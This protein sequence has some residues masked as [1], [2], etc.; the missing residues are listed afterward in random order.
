[1]PSISYF[2]PPNAWPHNVS[3]ALPIPSLEFSKK[4]EQKTL[5][6]TYTCKTEHRD[7]LCSFGLPWD[8]RRRFGFQCYQEKR[9]RVLGCL[10]GQRRFEW[11]WTWGSLSC[12]RWPQ[13]QQAWRAAWIQSSW[14]HEGGEKTEFQRRKALSLARRCLTPSMEKAVPFHQPEGREAVGIRH[15]IETS[16]WRSVRFALSFFVFGFCFGCC[17]WGMGIIAWG[18]AW[19]VYSSASFG[20]LRVA[21]KGNLQLS[22]FLGC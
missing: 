4:K 16:P 10:D 14:P 17:H 3:T 11:T 18:C 6:N 22:V 7:M 8:R 1:M 12:R 13:V 15:R 20:G 9:R 19:L 2:L 21:A 5:K